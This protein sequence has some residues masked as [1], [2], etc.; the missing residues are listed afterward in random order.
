MPDDGC[1]GLLQEFDELVGDAVEDDCSGLLQEFNEL[2]G[3]AAAVE[4]PE[5]GSA[6]KAV[7]VKGAAQS[8]A[9]VPFS[10]QLP[11]TATTTAD[12]PTTVP[13]TVRK[14]KCPTQ[15]PA[16]SSS[17]QSAAPAV[18]LSY[19]QNNIHASRKLAAGGRAARPKAALQLAWVEGLSRAPNFF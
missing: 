3:D 14:Q 6:F 2:M 8:R 16:G 18:F 9:P 13:M 12:A 1:S 10:L 7:R 5:P 11:A 19:F 4:S 17:V 15:R